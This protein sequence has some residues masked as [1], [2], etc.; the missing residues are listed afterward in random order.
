MIHSHLLK[1][2]EWFK[3]CKQMALLQ[4]TGNFNRVSPGY[5]AENLCGTRSETYFLRIE[6]AEA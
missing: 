6:V 1:P 2:T 4:S 3:Q 5:K